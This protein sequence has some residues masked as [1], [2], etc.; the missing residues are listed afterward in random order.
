MGEVPK[1]EHK[2]SSDHA[3]EKGA[4]DPR[5]SGSKILGENKASHNQALRSEDARVK[6]TSSGPLDSLSLRNP[7]N[8]TVQFGKTGKA[9]RF[10][11]AT[12]EVWTSVDG[13]TFTRGDRHKVLRREGDLFHL[14]D[15][16]DRQAKAQAATD[17]QRRVLNLDIGSV[18]SRHPSA[19]MP[20]K[21]DRANPQ[22]I[23][24]LAA[25]NQAPPGQMSLL[26]D[27]FGLDAQRRREQ[28]SAPSVPDLF[29]L[30]RFRSADQ[31]TG[32]SL[33]LTDASDRRSTPQA[34]ERVGVEY[35]KQ[36]PEQIMNMSLNEL[37]ATLPAFLEALQKAGYNP[38]ER[39][40][41]YGTGPKDPDNPF[42]SEPD[43][44]YHPDPQATDVLALQKKR[45]EAAPDAPSGP[46]DFFGLEA[47][48]L[49]EQ[50]FASAAHA[51]S[52]ADL[53]L[54]KD[55]TKA[56]VE[57]KSKDDAEP[58]EAAAALMLANASA[59]E[60][61]QFAQGQK[62]REGMLADPDRRGSLAYLLKVP[63]ED[64][65]PAQRKVYEAQK[66]L[67]LTLV[68][69]DL[70]AQRLNELETEYQHHRYEPDSHLY[71]T[72]NSELD[73]QFVQTERH[74]PSPYEDER[75]I[76]T[77]AEIRE[78]HPE[79]FGND[80]HP[81]DARSLTK[82]DAK[83]RNDIGVQERNACER[84][85]QYVRDEQMKVEMALVDQENR[86]GLPAKGANAIAENVGTSGGWLGSGY[87]N[88][89]ATPAMVVESLSSAQRASQS[90]IV[91]AD[92][93]KE[94]QGLA[95]LNTYHKNKV[96]CAQSLIVAGQHLQELAAVYKD[97]EKA[98][99]DGVAITANVAT[100]VG[101]ALISAGGAPETGGAS[102]SGLSAIPIVAGVAGK[103]VTEFLEDTTAITRQDED[104]YTLSQAFKDASIQAVAGLPMPGS[105][106]L[107]GAA[108]RKL[109]QGA[110]KSILG[111]TLVTEG[112]QVLAKTAGKTLLGRTVQSVSQL[113]PGAVA[114]ATAN[115][116]IGL[117]RHAAAGSVDGFSNEFANAV[118]RGD[119]DPLG[120]AVGGIIPGAIGGDLGYAVGSGIKK[121]GGVIKASLDKADAPR[122]HATTDLDLAT[123]TSPAAAH[124]APGQIRIDS[125]APAGS[126]TGLHSPGAGEIEPTFAIYQSDPGIPG[127][128][129]RFLHTMGPDGGFSGVDGGFSGAD[130]PGPRRP[131]DLTDRRQ[132]RMQEQTADLEVEV[133]D[134]EQVQK[135]NRLQKAPVA[136]LLDQV[137]RLAHSI[138]IKCWPG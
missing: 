75:I 88:S 132:T 108:T 97:R 96:E 6:E 27:I 118:I 79:I 137:L 40:L 21:A 1:H 121:V 86:H 66:D 102:L 26:G 128:G 116:G 115:F 63:E 35:L 133:H 98:F 25:R 32:D 111:K 123:T 78:R 101:I 28:L 72:G 61:R 51:P 38:K 13:K 117:A 85:A 58:K 135:A 104:R 44:L 82:E 87:F 24:L 119:K 76:I 113:T 92:T 125:G 99:S 11:E 71:G 109:A 37:R 70:L 57:A 60:Q 56:K 120:V 23:D 34:Y 81:V 29:G 17:R 2:K 68:T 112:E 54:G 114:R 134:K 136:I 42:V 10:E 8:S 105:R 15:A 64:L 62:I 41:G 39:V 55:K 4:V 16:P 45:D 106:F 110:G 69:G 30:N 129:G 31:R 14:E 65:T 19:S 107:E 122:V 43:K 22:S 59:E 103:V 138:P 48:K 80:A 67:Q 89:D 36:H 83:L 46:N 7:D 77:S 94:G 18:H 73:I 124:G 49:R 20:N 47:Q 12:G 93:I 91:S 90:L 127:R 100:T 9:E 84:L 126:S 52:A 53:L 33:Q 5:E 3:S 74:R 131:E 130:V 95:F 50:E